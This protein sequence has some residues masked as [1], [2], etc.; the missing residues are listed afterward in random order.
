SSLLDTGAS[1]RHLWGERKSVRRITSK[2]SGEGFLLALRRMAGLPGEPCFP[3]RPTSAL[4]GDA[5]F[6]GPGRGAQQQGLRAMTS[7]TP[8]PPLIPGQTRPYPVDRKST[9]LNSSH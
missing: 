4:D 3:S 7:A 5:A 1:R 2:F 8:K 6:A 9:R